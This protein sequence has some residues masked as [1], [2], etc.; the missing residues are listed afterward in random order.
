MLLIEDRRYEPSQTSNP[1]SIVVDVNSNPKKKLRKCSSSRASHST[2]H[3]FSSTMCRVILLHFSHCSR[4]QYSET[5]NTN[6]N[7]N[8]CMCTRVCVCVCVKI[9]DVLMRLLC[10]MIVMTVSLHH[11]HN[12]QHNQ[13]IN[14]IIDHDIVM[15]W[16]RADDIVMMWWWLWWL[17]WC[18]DMCWLRCWVDTLRYW[19]PV[20]VWIL[21]NCTAYCGFYSIIK[22]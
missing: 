10:W 20:Y 15:M 7:D 12:H 21:V 11:Q 9:V 19:S 17:W 3:K 16:L 8:V 14:T 13:F 2:V 6:P 4:W 5:W 1:S 18:D 22:E